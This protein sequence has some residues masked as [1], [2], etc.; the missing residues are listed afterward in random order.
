MA[1]LNGYEEETLRDLLVESLEMHMAVCYDYY[2]DDD[3]DCELPAGIEE[4]E[5]IRGDLDTYLTNDTGFEVRL[6][7]GAVLL[8]TVQLH[9]GPDED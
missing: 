1:N 8:V 4:I 3:D 7:N 9:R 2:D 6:T 5:Q